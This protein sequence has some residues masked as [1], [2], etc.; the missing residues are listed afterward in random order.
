[1]KI[2]IITDPHFGC[3][4]NSVYFMRQQSKFYK[5]KFFPYILKQDIKVVF[6]LGDFFDNR[7]TINFDTLRHS[8]ECFMN[9]IIENGIELHMLVGNHDSY[10][11]DTGELTSTK[12]L[13]KD[14]PNVH[15]YDELTEIEMG[16]RSI[17]MVPWIFPNQKK[18]VE[19]RLKLGAADIVC[20][21]FEMIGVAFQGNVL[22]RKGI[23]PDTFSQ[24]DHVFSGHFHKPSEYYV[25]SP[26]EMTWS[27]YDDPK[28]IIIYDTV[29]NEKE[30]V[31]LADRIFHKIEYPS[32]ADIHLEQYKDKIVRVLVKEKNSPIEFDNFIQR[33]ESHEPY[34][35]D[36]KEEYLYIDI[37]EE[38]ELDDDTD[39]L[40]V[41]LTSVDGI[42]DLKK[43]DKIIVK[44]ILNQLYNKAK[45]H[46]SI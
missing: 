10:F 29:R 37:I 42:D 24:Y 41:L 43:G 15:I 36:I 16:G 22:S 27:D 38:D 12:L 9:P 7:K 30:D 2:A 28:R 17:M 13:F 35:I 14:I 40:S 3:R 5:E 33:L 18:D 45:E 4:K 46:D 32:M 26:Y 21:H 23:D 44:E 11:K 39:T 6:L 19:E 34:E 20:G 25:G 31:F 1:M 8:K